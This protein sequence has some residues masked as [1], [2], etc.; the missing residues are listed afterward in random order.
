MKDASEIDFGKALTLLNVIKE[1]GQHGP[2]FQKLVS[3]AMEELKRMLD[4]NPQPKTVT[5]PQG[6]QVPNPERPAVGQPQMNPPPER[7]PIFPPNSGTKVEGDPG[8]GPQD[9]TVERRI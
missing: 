8:T 6:E 3:A 2:M 5:T 1:G 7:K 4:Y 9:G